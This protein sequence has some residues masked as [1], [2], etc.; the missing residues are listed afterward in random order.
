VKYI[1]EIGEYRDIISP[2]KILHIDDMG[3]NIGS[4]A[5]YKKAT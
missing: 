3:A 4:S 2:S 1:F 5:G